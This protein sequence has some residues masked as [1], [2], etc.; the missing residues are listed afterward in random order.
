[1]RRFLGNKGVVQLG[2]IEM[3]SGNSDRGTTDDDAT[4]GDVCGVVCRNGGISH[5]RGM[6]SSN[7]GAVFLTGGNGILSGC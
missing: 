1:M 2:V 7:E 5:G 4:G 3:M 6:R